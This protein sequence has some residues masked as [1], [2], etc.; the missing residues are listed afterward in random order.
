MAVRERHLGDRPADKRAEDVPPVAGGDVHD[1]QLLRRDR[2]QHALVV[3]P[4]LLA[5]QELGRDRRAVDAVS[6]RVRA[7]RSG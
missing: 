2:P 1:Q 7:V 3:L 4:V 6:K 5:V